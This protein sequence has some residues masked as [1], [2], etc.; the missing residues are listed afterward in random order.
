M[1]DQ[2]QY[3]NMFSESR[4]N[5]V[6]LISAN[7]SDPTIGAAQTRKWIYS[8]FP[9]VKAKDFSKFPFIVVHPT[10]VDIEQKGSLDGK[11]KFVSWNI[12]VEIV[13]CDRG[14]GSKD[15]DGLSH[16]DTL[17]NSLLNVFMNITNRTT[18]SDNSMKFVEPSTTAVVDEDRDN[19]KIYR[20]SILLAFRSRI[21]VSA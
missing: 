10:D 7:V 2:V 9:D 19:T 6:D 11:S 15:G 12:E 13:T 17:S 1:A 18:L 14:Y 21:K 3:N 16:M 20:R 8:R 4:D 5:V